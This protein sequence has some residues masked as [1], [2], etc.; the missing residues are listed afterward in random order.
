MIKRFKLPDWIACK[1]QK[2]RRRL[3]TRSTRKMTMLS[4]A[5][6]VLRRASDKDLVESDIKEVGKYV[7][8]ELF[9]RTI[10]VFDKQQ[11]IG[12]GRKIAQG[13]FEKLP[14]VAG[15]RQARRSGRRNGGPVHEHRMVDYEK[16]RAV[17]S[18][19]SKKKI[20]R[21]PGD[22]EFIHE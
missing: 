16:G 22:T 7:R 4:A 9:T 21:V 5:T 12:R 17:Q 3:T 6:D 18:L 13:L 2:T 19:A 14:I 20:K 8:G 1:P 10:F 15:E 11:A